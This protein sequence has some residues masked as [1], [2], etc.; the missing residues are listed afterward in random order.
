MTATT[1][2]IADALRAGPLT[3]R[4]LAS[5]VLAPKVELRRSL[6]A[7]LRRRAIEILPGIAPTWAVRY[8]LLE[9]AHR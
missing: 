5:A 1:L 6:D 8:A 4:R 7:L 9:G 3:Q 2:A